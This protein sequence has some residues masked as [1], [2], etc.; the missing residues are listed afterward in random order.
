[1]TAL[2]RDGLM[3]FWAEI[4]PDYMARFRA[5]H[6]CEHIPERVSIPGFIAGRRYVAMDGS[7][8]VLM[9]YETTDASVL[10]GAPYQARLNDPTPWTRESLGHFRNP[11]RNVYGLVADAGATDFFAA[12]Y[13]ISVRGNGAPDE[14]MVAELAGHDGIGRARLYA[15][16][17]AISGIKTAERKIYGGTGAGE[18]QWLLLAETALP[19]APAVTDAVGGW[20]DVLQGVFAMDYV[21]ERPGI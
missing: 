18:Q 8:R 16:D 3:V 12:P 7:T 21:L 17:E 2:A 15:L 4:D 19:D 5:W 11:S 10:G 13:M 20:R 6:N 9:M 14:G 1:M